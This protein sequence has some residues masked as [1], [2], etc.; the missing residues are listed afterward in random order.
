MVPLDLH[1]EEDGRLTELKSKGRLGTRSVVSSI[2]ALTPLERLSYV[3][4]V[5]PSS[6]AVWAVTLR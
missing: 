3:A 4:A 2:Q 1:R 6:E 5:L